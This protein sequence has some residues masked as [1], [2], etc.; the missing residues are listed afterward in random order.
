M[1]EL[2][3]FG[4]KMIMD[5]FATHLCGLI[6]PEFKLAPQSFKPKQK[7]VGLKHTLSA[8]IH[9]GEVVSYTFTTLRCT[10]GKNLTP[11]LPLDWSRDQALSQFQH[12]WWFSSLPMVRTSSMVSIEFALTYR[13]RGGGQFWVW[14]VPSPLSQE[15]CQGKIWWSDLG[16]TMVRC[17]GKGSIELVFLFGVSWWGSHWERKL[18][19]SLSLLGPELSSP[20][21]KKSK[22]MASLFCWFQE[23]EDVFGSAMLCCCRRKCFRVFVS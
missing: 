1:L 2:G 11:C 8:S 7:K 18:S 5:W 21:G 17:L 9:G 4:C 16:S 14:N 13:M 20:I 12:Y 6:S 19:P 15:P 23:L 22:K 3:D 10:S